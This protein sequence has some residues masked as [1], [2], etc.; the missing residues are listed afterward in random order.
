M[1]AIQYRNFW[2]EDLHTALKKQAI[3]E[4]LDLRDLIIKALEQYLEAQHPQEK[5]DSD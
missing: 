1:K 2:P 5:G 3:D 4:K